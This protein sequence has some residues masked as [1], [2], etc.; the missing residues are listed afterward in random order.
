MFA[1]LVKKVHIPTL[2][3]HGTILP[4]YLRHMQI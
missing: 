2:Y 3:K 1:V 4:D